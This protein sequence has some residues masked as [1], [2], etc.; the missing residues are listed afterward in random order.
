MSVADAYLFV[1]LV[2]A[3]KNAIKVPAA[4][5]SYFEGMKSRPAVQLA[6]KHE[7]LQL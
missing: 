6:I 3:R 4:L 7:G 1:M 2:W 5:T